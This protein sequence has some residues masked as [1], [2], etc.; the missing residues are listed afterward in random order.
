M[1]MKDLPMLLGIAVFTAGIFYLCQDRQSKV[2]GLSNSNAEDEDVECPDMLVQKGNAFF[3]YNS[4]VAR[5]PGVN[6]IQFKTLDEYTE[7]IDWQRSNGLRCPVLFLKYGYDAQGQSS[8]SI[9]PG[10][11]STQLKG[12][13]PSVKVRTSGQP[14]VLEGGVQGEETVQGEQLIQSPQHIT[15][16]GQ[17]RQPQIRRI[18]EEKHYEYD[19]EPIRKPSFYANAMTDNWAGAAFTQKLIDRGYYKNNEVSLRV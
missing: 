18:R 16:P 11:T 10:P 7:F 15:T 8:Y 1:G 12:G 9:R 3:L 4:K 2:E 19:I 14:R 13:L 5:V 17:S 6:P